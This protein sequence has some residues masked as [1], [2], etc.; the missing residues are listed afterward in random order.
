MVQLLIEAFHKSD[1]RIY[2][3]V[4]GI[5][6]ILILVSIGLFGL[7]LRFG[8]EVWQ[9]GWLAWL[10]WSILVV[11]AIELA[12]RV[13]TFTPPGS[14]LYQRSTIETVWFHIW[15]RFLYLIRPMN[16]ID[17]LAVLRCCSN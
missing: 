9:T 5:V 15:G 12:L 14:T 7:E 6:W 1:T 2:T 3:V 4:H 13:V 10:D 11:F 8:E 16:L 17:L